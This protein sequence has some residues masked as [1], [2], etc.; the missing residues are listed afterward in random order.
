MFEESID[1]PA[2]GSV[3]TWTTEGGTYALLDLPADRA[4]GEY[5]AHLL[6]LSPAETAVVRLALRG[7]RNAGIAERRGAS[8]RTVRNQLASAYAKLGVGSRGELAARFPWLA[9]DG[10][11]E[12]ADP[13]RAEDPLLYDAGSATGRGGSVCARA[14]I[15]HATYTTSEIA[16]PTNHA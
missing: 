4:P 15:I 12:G 14:A 11:T 1:A 6:G 8:P 10:L 3:V 2:E 16:K 7:L 9:D 13:R 5:F